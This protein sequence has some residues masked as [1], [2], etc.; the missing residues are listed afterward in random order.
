V[1]SL[2]TDIDIQIMTLKILPSNYLVLWKFKRSLNS[3][4]IK[5][6]QKLLPAKTLRGRLFWECMHQCFTM[7]L[8]MSNLCP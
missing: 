4:K 3:K 5:C 2:S 7:S 6:F 8:P 1:T